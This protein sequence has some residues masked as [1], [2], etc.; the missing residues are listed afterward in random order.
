VNRVH[1]W[2]RVI[3]SFIFIILFT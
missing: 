1:G 2:I 3:C